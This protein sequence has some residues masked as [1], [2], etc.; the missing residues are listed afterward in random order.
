MPEHM[1]SFMAELTYACR[2]SIHGW[3]I[4]GP[5]PC[6]VE[7]VGDQHPNDLVVGWLRVKT[8]EAEMSLMII[9][10]LFEYHCRILEAAP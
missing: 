6:P 4:A 7:I 1:L 8:S 9:R 5:E 3:F 2:C 10:H